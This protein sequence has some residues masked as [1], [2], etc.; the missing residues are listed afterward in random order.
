MK[1][2]LKAEFEK[3]EAKGAIKILL[4]LLNS[5]FSPISKDLESKIK[6]IRNLETLNT[7]IGVIMDLESVDEL[8]K[9][10]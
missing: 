7:L 9:L 5:K 10:L 6:K 3:I 2:Y 8:E 4:A 1:S